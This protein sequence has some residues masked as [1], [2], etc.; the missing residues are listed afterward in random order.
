MGLVWVAFFM[1]ACGGR[2]HHTASEPGVKAP[3]HLPVYTESELR[4]KGEARSACL[5]AC[6][7]ADKACRK[8]CMDKFPPIQ[9]EVVP[10]L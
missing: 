3:G 1:V 10:D 8:A 9:V 6:D 5:S 4:A 7:E 2:T